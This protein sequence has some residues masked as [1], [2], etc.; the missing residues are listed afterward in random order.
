MLFI[1]LL[2]R[3]CFLCRNVCPFALY[4]NVG[5]NILAV[6][7]TFLA[8]RNK[9]FNDISQNFLRKSHKE[10]SQEFFCV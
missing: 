1:Y 2:L 9:K 10:Y 3:D 5:I 4:W 7:F 8:K 6:Y